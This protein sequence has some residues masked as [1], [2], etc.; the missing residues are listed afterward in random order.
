M[1][2]DFYSVLGVNKS[3]SDKELKSAYRKLAVQWHPDKN[4]SPEA[5]K[6]FKEINEAYEVL[7]DSK[8]KQ[9]YDQFGHAAFQNGAGSP[10]GFPGGSPFGAGSGPFNF[11][12]R[13]YGGGDSPFEGFDFSDP[14]E[15]FEQFFGGAQFG[16]SQR[17]PHV[18]VS[19]DFMHAYKGAETEV[20]IDGKKRKVK[21]PPGVDDGSRIKFEDFL[22]TINVRPHKTFQR[23]GADIFIDLKIS[24]AT[25]I[26]GGE[27]EIPTLDGDTKIRVRPGT[28]HGTLLRLSGN[29]MPRLQGRGRGDFYVRIHIDI[30]EH[31]NLTNEQKRVLEELSK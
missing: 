9:A 20:A 27:V 29:G 19:I 7:G 28:Q 10:G 2:N 22:V 12:Y 18:S 1:K 11:T 15:I 6:K 14:F 16:R 26:T 4:K 31:K 21:I 24:L 23:D 5:E 17:V 8:K 30:P 13:Q 3:A 25:A